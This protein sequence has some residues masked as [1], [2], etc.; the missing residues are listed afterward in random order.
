MSENTALHQIFK[1]KSKYGQPLNTYCGPF[2][3]FVEHR[4]CPSNLKIKSLQ[5]F[6]DKF[7]AQSSFL[8]T[9][10]LPGS[11]NSP[12]KGENFHDET[13]W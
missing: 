4:M 7:L 8:L 3:I 12:K 11:H 10:L 1:E 5:L 2:G 13:K 6:K 9:A